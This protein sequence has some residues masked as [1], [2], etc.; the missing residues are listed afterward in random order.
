MAR[1]VRGSNFGLVREDFWGSGRIP[2]EESR[3]CRVWGGFGRGED[4]S[5]L[6]LVVSFWGGGRVPRDASHSSLDRAC[7]VDWSSWS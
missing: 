7:F 5:G 3:S 2:R 4:E 1:D 6:R